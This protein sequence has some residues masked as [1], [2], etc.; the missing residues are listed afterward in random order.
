MVSALVVQH[1]D[2]HLMPKGHGKRSAADAVRE[3]RKRQVQEL[4]LQGMRVGEIA[5]EI[6]ATIAAVNGDIR[7]FR[8]ELY[9]SSQATLQEHSE[10]TVAV[11]RR[12]QT[13]LWDSFRAADTEPQRLKIMK[14]I[15]ENES[16]VAKV[17]GVLSDKVIADVTHHIKMYD[18]NDTLP[19]APKVSVRAIG[20]NTILEGEF[21]ETTE[22]LDSGTAVE[23]SDMTPP[24]PTE[25]FAAQNGHLVPEYID[26][27]AVSKNGENV[28]LGPDGYWYEL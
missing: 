11:L 10:Q 19:D 14:Q 16:V 17:R 4:W 27:T 8:K 7:T 21:K 12:I 9:E 3:L 1:N 13:F 23:L 15:Q 24:P 18:F 22:S 25:E 28:V 5:L 6:D 20:D 2:T 26:N